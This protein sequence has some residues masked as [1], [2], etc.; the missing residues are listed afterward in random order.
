MSSS[1]DEEPG[2]GEVTQ[3]VSLASVAESIEGLTDLFRRRLLDDR[4]KARAFDL[5]Y[6]ELRTAR[7]L[8][9]GEVVLPLARRLFAVIDRIEHADDD[10]V[11]SVRDELVGSLG[12]C[13][14][15]D[16][17]PAVGDAFDPS[18]QEVI[19]DVDASSVAI[20][21]GVQRRGWTRNGQL[22]RTALVRLGVPDSDAQSDGDLTEFDLGSEASAE[23]GGEP[24]RG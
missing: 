18:T 22:I 19:G 7:G 5:L 15:F 16:V 11:A 14:I 20:V 23:E 4:E 24:P 2:G 1:P 12:N 8:I 9:E 17:Q 21:M 3:E 6:E 13:G 10:L